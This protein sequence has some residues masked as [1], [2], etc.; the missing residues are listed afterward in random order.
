MSEETQITNET[1]V[2]KEPQISKQNPN[3]EP[4]IL[5]EV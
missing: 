1:Q 5:K 2:S 4:Q 3:Y